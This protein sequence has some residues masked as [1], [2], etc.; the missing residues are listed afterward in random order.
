MT[1][2]WWGVRGW[3]GVGV[4]NE[5][6]DRGG[7]DDLT[8]EFLIESGEGL[9]CM[10]RCLNDLQH[11]S[12]SGECLAEIFRAVHTMKGTVGF[13]GFPRLEQLAHAG[14]ALLVLLRDGKRG[15]DESVVYLLMQLTDR[16]RAVLQLIETRGH[17]GKREVDDDSG[18]IEA[19]ERM[20]RG[21]ARIA[22]VAPA[23]SAAGEASV[24]VGEIQAGRTEQTVRVEVETLNR[25][26]NLVGDLVQTR[27]Q[28]LQAEVSEESF[29]RLG[30][31]LDGVTASLRETVMQARMQP[32]GHLFQRIPRLARDVAAICG[33]RVRLEF[34][35]G[36]TGLDKSLLETLKDPLAHAVRNAIDH[37][38]ESAQ[39]R[40]RK[41]KAA[42]GRI[43]LRAFH[44]GG[45][46]VVEVK[47]D[48]AGVDC[49]KVVLRAVERGLIAEERAVAMSDAEKMELLFAAGFSTSD[50]VTM[51][52]GRGV[53][54]DV[55]RANVEKI[56]GSVELLSV[57]GE[58]ATLR[59][60]VPLTLAIVPALIA[61][62]GGQMFAIPHS[63]LLEM[64]VVMREDEAAVVKRIGSAKMYLLRDRLVPLLDLSEMLGIARN[65]ERGYYI[66]ILEAKGRQF[67]LIVDDMAEPQEIVVKPLSSVLS[68]LGVY[69]GATILGDGKIALILDTTGMAKRAKLCEA[70]DVEAV[71]ASAK[72]PV[73]VVANERK[74]APMLVFANH[75]LEPTVVPLACVERIERVEPEAIERLAGERVMQYRDELVVL[76][77]AGG[78]WQELRDGVVN[79]AWL[80]LICRRSGKHARRVGLVVRDA[81]DVLEG[82]LLEADGG[83]VVRA[84]G[85]LAMFHAGFEMQR[86]VEDACLME[87]A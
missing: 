35:G 69:S 59:M 64:V 82:E 3:D 60:R 74:R 55:V 23:A 9:D 56:G 81:L 21:E 39:E 16:L 77:D 30:Q 10:E 12:E 29:A 42:E 15:V 36:A 75:R 52:S 25:L 58:G 33:K 17:E 31:R 38:V 51:I 68:G 71:A 14:E 26:M 13:L 43:E 73:E 4:A 85:R 48:G 2:L 32:V 5:G 62:C 70:A 11:G 6:A 50:E 18:L 57:R 1:D 63:T 76:E 22:E 61:N 54:L 47:D 80:V 65:Q 24:S 86:V 27:N 34:S 67:G 7:V 28:F 44:E 87:A 49:E 72:R 40:L 84:D 37:G 19:L 79:E 41:G 83:S 45:Q 20:V 66:A 8:K 53:G 78:L 46:I